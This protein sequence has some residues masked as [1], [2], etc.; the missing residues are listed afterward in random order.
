MKYLVGRLTWGLFMALSFAACMDREFDQMMSIPIASLFP[1]LRTINFLLSR[2]YIIN[3][4]KSYLW[5][6]LNNEVANFSKPELVLPLKEGNRDS[7]RRIPL[8]GLLYEYHDTEKEL[9]F[10]NIPSQF[11]QQ[12]MSNYPQY[13]N[14]RLQMIRNK[15]FFL[16]D[17][18][19]KSLRSNIC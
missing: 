4:S 11:I 9:T 5:F 7:Y 17:K 16:M 3:E 18:P 12:E 1:Q 19:Q 10:K 8:R 15:Y 14:Y 13:S 6:D 2:I